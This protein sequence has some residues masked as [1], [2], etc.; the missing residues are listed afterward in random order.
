[1]EDTIALPDWLV[2][3]SVTFGGMTGAMHG[4]RKRMDV[5]GT[6]IVAVIAAIGAGTVRDLC[7]GR[8]PIWLYSPLVGYA[9]LGGIAGYF[10]ARAMKYINRTIFLLDTLLIG[11]WVALGAELALLYGLAPES[12]VLLGVI[13]AVGGGV[14]RD[15]VCRDIPTAFN[16]AQ[17]ETLGAFIAAVIFV[18]ADALLP[19]GFAEALAIVSAALIRSLA[20]RFRWRSIS[21]VELSERLRGRKSYYDPSTGT[22]TVMRVAPR[23]R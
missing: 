8:V 16:P 18:S 22:L 12:A 2:N 5:F 9:V 1:M 21:A 11:V 6:L 4:A 7:I 10:L 23:H 19:R 13:T 14:I 17:F 3:V 20:L 15:V